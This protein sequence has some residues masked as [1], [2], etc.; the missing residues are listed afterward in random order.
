M[1]R[2]LCLMLMAAMIHSQAQQP[3]VLVPPQPAPAAAEA[4]ESE[5][6]TIARCLKDL[7]SADV[8]VRRKAALLLGKYRTAEADAA[9]IRC[10]QDEDA[11]IRLGA[12][13][14]LTEERMLPPEARGDIFR[15]LSDADVHVRR[16]ASALLTDA[17]GVRLRGNVRLSGNVRIQSGSLQTQTDVD[18]ARAAI[19]TALNDEDASV[20]RNVLSASRL[21]PEALP[22]EHVRKFL[23]DPS[24]EVR[25]LAIMMYARMAGQHQERMK[26][27]LPL[28]KDSSA[29]VRRELCAMCP[30][31][32]PEGMIMLRQ[33]L[34]DTDIGVR[35]EAVRQL[36]YQQASDGFE[37]LQKILLDETVPVAKRRELL[38][39][40]H[41]YP[42]RARGIYEKLLQGS[43]PILA[44]E[45]MEMLAR[46]LK[47]GMDIA[48]FIPYVDAEDEKIAATAFRAIRMRIRELKQADLSALLQCRSHAARLFVVQQG[49]RLIPREDVGE[50]LLEACLDDDAQVRQE[51]FRR[52]A[53]FR[54][55][56]WVEALAASLDDED[57][58]IAETAATHLC[59]WP[60]AAAQDA[61]RAYLP[62]CGNKQL[63]QRI[64]MALRRRPMTMTRGQ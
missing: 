2:L 36:V 50:I 62:K 23:S 29:E 51:T 47:D 16:Q 34:Q 9:M 19:L 37:L 31:L 25:V 6:Q 26:D 27:L 32:G 12:L 7:E 38:L 42:D 44:R 35:I 48:F 53:E 11:K 46:P 56:G 60:T 21:L 10:L 49:V 43:S 57:Q 54:P 1:R 52:L 45:A 41:G 33:L 15:L 8:M 55:E 61:L 4:R 58:T 14:S 64:E 20:R 59:R 3:V 17:M 63:I 18:E 39:P 22:R 28:M 24:A 13:V 5:E 40:L 30:V